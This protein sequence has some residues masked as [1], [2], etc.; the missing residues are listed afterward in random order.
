M[1]FYT[2][3]VQPPVLNWNE[4]STS[5]L[6]HLAVEASSPTDALAIVERGD[7]KGMPAKVVPPPGFACR[8][9]LSWDPPREPPIFD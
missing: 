4:P 3:Q 6:W 1:S 8:A 7:R 9:D 2:V 5:I